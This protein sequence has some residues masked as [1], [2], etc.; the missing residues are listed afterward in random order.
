MNILLKTVDRCEAHALVRILK[1]SQV[2]MFLVVTSQ[3]SFLACCH[4]SE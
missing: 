1:L 2:R 4:K 3:N